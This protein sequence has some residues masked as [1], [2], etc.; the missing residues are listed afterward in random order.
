VPDDY[1]WSAHQALLNQTIVSNDEILTNV[2][3]A[4]V[5]AAA[6]DLMN[7]NYTASC[8]R[9]PDCTDLTNAQVSC[10]VGYDLVGYD[11]AK[12]NGKDDEVC[13]VLS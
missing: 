9:Q 7:I 3:S 4:A 6:T 11:R 1:E 8:F 12:C 10:G 2:L 5:K 13:S